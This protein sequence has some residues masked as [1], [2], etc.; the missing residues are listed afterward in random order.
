MK[1]FK[2]ELIATGFLGSNK[3]N[4]NGTEII[5]REYDHSITVREVLMDAKIKL[6]FVGLIMLNN[7]SIDQGFLINDSCCIKLYP[8]LGGG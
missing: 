3:T 6:G 4:K 1:I 7:K 2:V 5:E 8:L